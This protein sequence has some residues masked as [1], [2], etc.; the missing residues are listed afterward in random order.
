AGVFMRTPKSKSK[1]GVVRALQAA[2]WETGIGLAC[3]VLAVVVNIIRPQPATIFLG[4]LL[5][6]QASLYFAAP[7]YSLYSVRGQEPKPVA[8]MPRP[9]VQ[10]SWI[11]R[12]AVALALG[13]VAGVVVSQLLPAPASQPGYARFQPPDVPVRRLV[14]LPPAPTLVPSATELPTNIP[15]TLQ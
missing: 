11:A 7:Y 14:G 12:W 10:E 13:M 8:E 4:V 9:T 5:V 6:W 3:V 15:P 1:S 2:Q